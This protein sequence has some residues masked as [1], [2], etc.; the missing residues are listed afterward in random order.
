MAKDSRIYGT[1][2]RPISVA[3][4][5][6]RFA[7]GPGNISACSLDDIIVTGASLGEDM[8]NLR[9]VFERLRSA[10]SSMPRS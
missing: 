1:R 3:S 7:F 5:A 8:D 4:H 2:T 9:K 10:A 6:I